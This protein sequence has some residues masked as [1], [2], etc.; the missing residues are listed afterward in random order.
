MKILYPLVVVM[1]LVVLGLIG[2]WLPGLRGLFGIAIPYV[3]FAVL[4]LG[5]V[6]RV[7]RWAQSPV[8]FRIP[9]TAGQQKALDWI[10][11]SR[12]DNPS[13]TL[14]VIGRM[15]LE[16]LFFRSLFRNTSMEI[17]GRRVIY[18]ETKLLWLAG[19]AFHWSML[20]VLTRHLRFF[21]EPVPVFVQ[22][23]QY[24]D[25]FLQ[26]GV[27]VVYITTLVIIASLT[28]LLLRRI[29]IPQVRY[30]SL[31]ADYLAVFLILG[32]ALTGGLMRHFFRTDVVAVKELAMGLVS[33]RPVV[34]DSVSPLFFAHLLLVSTLMAYFPLSKLMHAGGVFLS[35]TRNLANNNRMRR[36]VNPWNY[37][38]PVHTYAEW[39]E[40][41]KDK[42]IAAGIPLD[43]E[44]EAEAAAPHHPAEHGQR[45]QM[46][47]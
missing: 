30:V 12:L 31:P 43:E 29:A 27:P 33:L 6:Y 28:Y 32:I 38:V 46:A 14:G 36:H 37:P 39:Q 2:G 4:V 35:P 34:P 19:L 10:K 23:L 3:A 21:A 16:I 42:L 13:D 40:E 11:P 44:I 25:G 17:R 8:P 20:L 7:I 45:P 24:L 41:F 5:F 22:L 15:A 26:M 18:G 9:T 47:V 1:A